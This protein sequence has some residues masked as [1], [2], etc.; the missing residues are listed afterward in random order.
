MVLSPAC[1]G[2]AGPGG[3]YPYQDPAYP[4]AADYPNQGGYPGAPETRDDSRYRSG[5]TDDPYRP[6]GYSGYHS[7]QGL[8]NPPRAPRQMCRP[9]LGRGDAGRNPVSRTQLPFARLATALDT[10]GLHAS[11]KTTYPAALHIFIPGATMLAESIDCT[12]GTDGKGRLR[13][14]YRS[15]WGNC[16]M[17]RRILPP[18]PRRSPRYCPHGEHRSR[19]TVGRRTPARSRAGR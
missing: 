2:A 19:L 9:T 14:Y 6:D 11:V 7:R 12:P 4:A 8:T 1:G 10:K 16:C 5:H 15:S 18:P 13:W 17:T 3:A